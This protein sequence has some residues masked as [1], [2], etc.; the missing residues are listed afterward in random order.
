M[1]L[2]RFYNQK[3][4]DTMNTRK[5]VDAIRIQ[6][7]SRTDV[8]SI[9]PGTKPERLP[10]DDIT[11]IEPITGWAPYT[12]MIS[13]DN[14]YGDPD[15]YHADLGLETAHTMNTTTTTVTITRRN[16]NI[17]IAMIPGRASKHGPWMEHPVADEPE[18][19]GTVRQV[20]EYRDSRLPALE[21]SAGSF[22]YFVGDKR[23]V[24]ETIVEEDG[25]T[26]DLTANIF[27][28]LDTYEENEGRYPHYEHQRGD[29]RINAMDVQVE[30]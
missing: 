26:F 6:Y 21:A 18:F 23:I 22:T 17:G 1:E 27:D 30:M 20:M 19:V 25:N 11:I 15:Y 12:H 10:K 4:C 14:G 5:T 3:G 13:I 8:R 24:P 9:Y 2:R 16:R 28:L 7:D 29:Y